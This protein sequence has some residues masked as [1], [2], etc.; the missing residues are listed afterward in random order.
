MSKHALTIARGAG[1]IGVTMALMVGATFAALT[2]NPVTLSNNNITSATASL[3]V[4]NGSTYDVTAT[5]FT[6]NN[7]IPGSGSGDLPFYLENDGGTP[8]DLSVTVPTAPTASGFTGWD[9]FTVKI[10]NNVGAET[11]TTM[12]ALLAGQVP[13]NGLALPAG[14]TG[15]GGV[16]NTEGNFTVAFDINKT[17]VTG[18][19]ATVGSFNLV[20]TGT[21][22]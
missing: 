18:S 20:F 3:K 13:L 16:P 6:V 19:Q 14:A 4:W 7:L 21:Q 15:N 12:Q 2:S 9:N 1:V 17:A 5:G 10:K 11:D 22:H 8:L